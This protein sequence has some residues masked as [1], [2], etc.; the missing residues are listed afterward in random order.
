MDLNVPRCRTEYRCLIHPPYCSSHSAKS[1]VATV[2]PLPVSPARVDNDSRHIKL[3][4]HETNGSLYR[5]IQSLPLQ[6]QSQPLTGTTSNYTQ[7]STAT[8]VPQPS[9]LTA[10]ATDAPPASLTIQGA[11]SAPNRKDSANTESTD[12]ARIVQDPLAAGP[13]LVSSKP[14][15][16]SVA[17]ILPSNATLATKGRLSSATPASE[18]VTPLTGDFPITV[19]SKARAESPS[20][21]IPSATAPMS[22]LAEAGSENDPFDV[23][24]TVNVLT[25]QFLSDHAETR[26]AAL[27]W[28]LMLHLKAPTQASE[29]S[30][31]HCRR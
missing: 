17:Q 31:I 16:S 11:P 27:E 20:A 5:V 13:P 29:L 25:L 23:R 30:P 26:I 14:S 22:P 1:G 9:A 6:V 10:Q 7:P 21:S 18:P 12:A 19:K 28:L 2:S 4:A 24:E 8:S 3:A 15:L